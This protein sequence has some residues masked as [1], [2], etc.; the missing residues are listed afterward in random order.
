MRDFFATDLAALADTM[1]RLDWQY[2][3]VRCAG[4]RTPPARYG[5]SG[6]VEKASD[7]LTTRQQ[8]TKGMPWSV[9]ASAALA[10]LCP[11]T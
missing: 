3:R 1:L 7:G 2:L 11:R 5:G 6:Q 4:K 8:N 9:E 10:A